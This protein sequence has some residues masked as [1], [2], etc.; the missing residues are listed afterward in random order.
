MGAA[1][2]RLHAGSHRR[3]MSRLSA[4]ATFAM[5]VPCALLVT[6]LEQH[7]TASANQP[8]VRPIKVVRVTKVVKVQK[9]VQPQTATP[10]TEMPIR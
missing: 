10:T 5:A 1:Q 9:V 6:G 2:S 7:P 3:R 8:V 4:V